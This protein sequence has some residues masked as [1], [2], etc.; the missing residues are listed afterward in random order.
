[1]IDETRDSKSR[2]V[3][4]TIA[5]FFKTNE[6]VLL[7]TTFEE[8]VDNYT[9][10]KILNKVIGDFHLRW[11]NCIGICSDNAAYITLA[12]EKLMELNNKNLMHIRCFCHICNLSIGKISSAPLCEYFIKLINIWGKFIRKNAGAQTIYGKKQLYRK[13][14]AKNRWKSFWEACIYLKNHIIVMKQFI[15]EN[16]EDF[17]GRKIFEEVKKLIV[18]EFDASKELILQYLYENAKDFI[19]SDSPGNHLI[20]DKLD[21]LVSKFK[22]ACD[23]NFFGESYSEFIKNNNIDD[24]FISSE[25]QKM[26][27]AALKN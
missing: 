18:T 7:D 3:I 1:M 22:M 12:V 17:A 27:S 11:E 19:E 20:N 24:T 6:Y 21:L 4:N 15:S 23:N 9:I 13:A 2:C 8:S 14:Y 26:S 5:F 10:I 25:L 16:T